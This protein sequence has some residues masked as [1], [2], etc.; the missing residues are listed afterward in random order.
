MK[1][2]ASLPV[3]ALILVVLSLSPDL[4]AEASNPSMTASRAASQDQPEDVYVVRVYYD[5]IEDI[6]LL[7]DYDL[8]EYNNRDEKYVLVAVDREKLQSLEGLGLRVAVDPEETAN[9]TGASAGGGFGIDTIGGK[10]CYRTVEETYQTA[11]DIATDHPALATWIDVG[12]SW[13]KATVT[14]PDLTGYDM[15][16]L[17]LTNSGVDGPGVVKPKLFITAS[18]HAREYAPAE[19][20][21]RFAEYMV[22][23]HGTDADVTWIL[24]HHELH[25]MF[26]ANPDGRKKAEAGSGVMWRKNTDRD[27][28]CTSTVV[29]SSYYGTDLNRN[30]S[31]QWGTGGSSTA[32]CNDSY[33]GPSAGSEPET[34]VIQTYLTDI[35]PDQREGGAAPPDTSG[36]YIDIHSHGGYVIWPWGYS[37]SAP[38]NSAQLQTLGRKFAYYNNYTPGQ[39]TGVLYVAS[40]GGVD[41]SY[42]E[43]GVASYA[44]EVGTAFFQDCASFENTIYPVNLQAL[45][46]AA[47][48]AR[49]PYMT[50][51]GPDAL[52]LAVS[53]TS[54]ACGA[55]ATLTGTINDTRYRSGTGEPTQAIAAAEYYV[56]TPPWLGGTAYAMTASDGSFNSTTEGVTASVDTADLSTGRHILFVRGQDAAGNWG[57]FSANFLDVTPC[58]APESVTNLTITRLDST[59]VEVEWSASEG[60]HH[61]EVWSASDAPYF[62]PGADCDHPEPYTCK[63]ETG[64]STTDASLGSP[65]THTVYVVRAVSSCGA[66]SEFGSGRAGEFEYSLVRGD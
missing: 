50:P 54:V 55:P 28:G 21:T 12:D 41:Y 56:D 52:N 47:K 65:A 60:A 27:D 7:S 49:T 10:E 58:V 25:L 37:A 36:I 63:T 19:L 32:P 5:T 1:H 43:L 3:L 13:E 2:R 66:V 29:T 26:Q 23:N 61:Y 34:Q 45:I 35:F 62:A 8:F 46:Y 40:G 48:V 24:D 16:V 42:G 4:T 22:D 38:P 30:F 44:I 59:Q 9:F 17:R 64:T 18:I 6:G 57:A 51:A 33:R 53:P 15:M 31:Y 11:Q 14:N 20:L 39:I